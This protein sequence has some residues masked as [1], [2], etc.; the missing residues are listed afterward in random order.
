MRCLYVAVKDMD[1]PLHSAVKAATENPA[2]CIGVDDRYG[3]LE[4][5]HA[6]DAVL[7]DKGTLEIRAVVLRG[8]LL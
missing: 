6:A 4:P 3:S 5:G 7:L 8:R 2:R 1:I